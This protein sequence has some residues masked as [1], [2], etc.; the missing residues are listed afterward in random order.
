MGEKLGAFF[1]IKDEEKAKGY[2]TE[3]ISSL[4]REKDRT[5]DMRVT[6]TYIAVSM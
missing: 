1:M 6:H 4:K 5:M 3:Q 2:Q